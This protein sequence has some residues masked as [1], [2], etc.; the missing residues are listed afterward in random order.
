VLEHADLDLP[1]SRIISYTPLAL[2]LSNRDSLA[3]GEL[4]DAA[5]Y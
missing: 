1:A 4:R 3:E 5:L 2:R